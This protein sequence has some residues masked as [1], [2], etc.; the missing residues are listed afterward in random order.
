M[1][2]I[3]SSNPERILWCCADYGITPCELA[4]ALGIAPG[5]IER[6]M[7]VEDGITFNQLRKVADFFGC[8]VL[9]FLEDGPVD[10]AQVHTTQFRTQTNQ[11]PEVFRRSGGIVSRLSPCKKGCDEK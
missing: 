4:A 2:R 10:A 6:L 7:A 5:S 1:Y 8:G 9:F 11:K 3:Q